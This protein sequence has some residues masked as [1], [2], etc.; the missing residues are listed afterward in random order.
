MFSATSLQSVTVEYFAR[1]WDHS[2]CLSYAHFR[3]YP[4][5]IPSA[6]RI[7]P[8]TEGYYDLCHGLVEQRKRLPLINADHTDLRCW[9][10]AEMAMLTMTNH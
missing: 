9:E 1:L 4:I 10:T 6:L 5:H 2:N 3:S 8:R 7:L